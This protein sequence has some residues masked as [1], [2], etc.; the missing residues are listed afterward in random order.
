M[1]KSLEEKRKQLESLDGVKR[2]LSK[3]SR[4]GEGPGQQLADALK[5]GDFAQASKQLKD[6]AQKLQD[7]SLNA[8]EKKELAKQLSDLQKQLQQLA[9]MKDRA[10]QLKKSVPPDMLKKELEKLAQDAK[11]LE[12]LKQLA[13]KLGQCSKCMGKDGESTGKELESALAEAKKIAD[14]MMDE[15]M[16]QAKL[17]EM[18]D[19]LQECRGG[20][21]QG[22]G[23]KNNARGK[24]RGAG[25]REEAEDKTRSRDVRSRTKIH[26]GPASIVGR[27]SGKNFKGESRLELRQEAA[28]AARAADEA[29]TRQKIPAE[30]RDHT[31]D[32]FQNL[33]G[34]LKD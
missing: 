3:L 28:T 25:E 32:Y 17:D 5:Q 10:E 33:N 16:R 1:A 31:R 8:Q 15:E 4:V 7:K 29:V 22:E 9:D 34:S 20:M 26:R 27:T 21:C 12:Q 13:E 19:D 30:Y 11:Q 23:V 14:Q 6:L 2:N 24:G 18:L